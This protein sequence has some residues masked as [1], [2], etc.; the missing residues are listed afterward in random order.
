MLV[1]AL[2]TGPV[3][4]PTSQ[5]LQSLGNVLVGAEL[6]GSGVSSQ[7]DWIVRELRLPR[8]LLAMLVGAGLAVAGAI[9]QGV[10]R[11]PLADPGLIGVSSGAALAA[12]AVIV[13]QGSLLS[14]Y[15]A[16]FGPFALPVAAFAGGLGVTWLIYRL[17]TCQGQTQMAMLLLAGVAINVIAGALTGILTYMADDQQ[18]RS[19]TF[20]SMGSLAHGKWSEIAV[21]ALCIA[22]P[23]LALPR[24]A[25]LLNALLM[26]E[27]VAGHLGFAVQRGKRWLIV[28][29]ALMVGAGV[30]VAGMIGFIGLVVPHLLRLLMG[31]DHKALLPGCALLGATLLLVADTIARTWLAPA[32]LPVGLVMAVI[33]GP[34]FL[35]L[36]L[37]QSRRVLA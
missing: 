25:A 10:F 7:Q 32:D 9:T 24:F 26:G 3:S 5:V 31:P 2:A 30:A 20:W 37:Q 19:M 36:L 1:L 17:S 11:N 16:F 21:L 12:V 15:A 6:S 13:L 8:V 14:G 27:A 22:V 29:A 33:G 28:A 4:V 35:S 34:V 18:L 23:L